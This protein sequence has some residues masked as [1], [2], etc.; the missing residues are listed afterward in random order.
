MDRTTDIIPGHLLT[1]ESRWQEKSTGR[2]RQ[3]MVNTVKIEVC[4][5]DPSFARAI[6]AAG[7]N[8]IEMCSA[9]DLGGLTPT[10]LSLQRS[11]QSGLP[12]TAM[13]RLRP[14][15]FM[16]DA[17]DISQMRDEISSHISAGAE[18]IVLG[19]LKNSRAIDTEAL[20]WLMDAC[21][22]TPVTFHRAFDHCC[23]RILGL[24]QIIDAGCQRL[25][26]SGGA[27][28]ALEGIEEVARIVE[29]ADGRI[30]VMAGGGV[31]PECGAELVRRSGVQWL[32]LSARSP[33]IK[34]GQ[35]SPSRSD[36]VLLGPRDPRPSSPRMVT[37]PH[38][39]RQLAIELGR[40]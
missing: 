31:R 40:E 3:R 11:I 7:A 36:P 20:S 13:T 30:E 25:L 10:A 33:A 26:T 16:L 28:S 6:A 14:G 22:G 29:A 32:H 39:I 4:I 1:R 2:K 8:R 17:E 18:G 34:D 5:D 9:L 21:N 35:G 15:D 23:D 27:P 37:D 24:E 19:V 38:L 12:V